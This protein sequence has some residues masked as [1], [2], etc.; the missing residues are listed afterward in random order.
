[1]TFGLPGPLPFPYTQQKG[2]TVQKQQNEM[3][4][5]IPADRVREGDLI[6]ADFEA[7]EEG[8]E[9][10]CLR[11]VEVAKY[12]G[13]VQIAVIFDEDADDKYVET[14][15]FDHDSPTIIVRRPG[16]GHRID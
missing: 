8:R 10:E 7:Y 16:D 14:F 6:P 9:T 2:N 4:Y 15:S 3:R 5:L 11:V 1:M 12:N 13:T